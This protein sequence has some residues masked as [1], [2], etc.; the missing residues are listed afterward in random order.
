MFNTVTTK[1]LIYSTLVGFTFLN[2]CTKFSFL[3]IQLG[4]A[5]AYSIRHWFLEAEPHV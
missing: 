5:D 1:D 4:C 3:Y 2:L